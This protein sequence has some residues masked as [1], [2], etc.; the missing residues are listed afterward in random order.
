MYCAIYLF[1]Y[2]TVQCLFLIK[3]VDDWRSKLN[4]TF[5]L[6]LNFFFQ[7]FQTEYVKDN[8]AEIFDH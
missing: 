5:V 2:L 4:D 6:F 1:R 7:I 3:I 8:T